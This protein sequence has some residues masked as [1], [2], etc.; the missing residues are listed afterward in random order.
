M[1]YF[2][3]NQLKCLKNEETLKASDNILD[4]I[5]AGPEY[6]NDP[7]TM[8]FTEIILGPDFLKFDPLDKEFLMDAYKVVQSILNANFSHL[9]EVLVLNSKANNEENSLLM[10]IVELFGVD[11]T[12]NDEKKALSLLKIYLTIANG[13]LKPLRKHERYERVMDEVLDDILDSRLFSFLDLEKREKYRQI[14][15]GA[16]AWDLDLIMKALLNEK[17][18]QEAYLLYNV[19]GCLKA[20][21]LLSQGDERLEAGREAFKSFIVSHIQEGSLAI[22][23]DLCASRWP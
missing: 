2:V 9:F 3:L 6:N 8:I 11:V 20:D 1:N 7:L 22:S 13:D 17:T 10:G 18:I 14:F 19:Y 15:L 12:S 21:K 5:E 23:R 16:L 4:F